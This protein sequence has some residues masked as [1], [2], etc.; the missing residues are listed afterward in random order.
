MWPVPR[1]RI[2]R[3]ASCVPWIT[4][5]RLISSW[6]VMLASD[7][8]SSGV[9]GMIPALLTRM[10]IGPEAALDVVEEGGE[11]GE[12]GDVE[13]QADDGVAELGGGALR[14]L[15]VDVADRDA[16]ALGD[17][18]LRDRPPD[19]PGAAGDDGGLAAQRARLLG[20][21]VPFLLR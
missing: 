2:R 16:D 11:A 17:Q 15:A 10:S 8:S 6:R 1:G 13:R 9:I 21:A 3:I 4:A 19:A 20:H 12:V 7:S 18:R 5:R 14:G